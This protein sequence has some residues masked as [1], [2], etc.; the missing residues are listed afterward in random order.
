MR[1]MVWIVLLLAA[2]ASPPEPPQPFDALIGRMGV[3]TL[4]NLHADDPRSRL[5]AINYQQTGLIPVC[6]AV[7]LL[8]RNAKR[9]V[10]RHD[11]TGRTYEYYNHEL[12][13]EPFGEHLA[14][15]FGTECPRVALDALPEL[16]RQGIAH[17]KAFVG[18]SKQGVIFAMGYPP[19]HATP[20]LEGNR[21]LYWTNRFDKLAVYFDDNA[22]VLTIEN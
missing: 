10:F 18:M 22:R 15:Y 5:F 2:C 8:E 17:G 20:S 9:L 4:T 13:A 7:T 3:V 16:D 21:W 11:A 19:T 12:I 1:G 14:R 6:S